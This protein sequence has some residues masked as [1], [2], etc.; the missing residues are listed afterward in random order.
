M[1]FAASSFHV[2]LERISL[3]H[4]LDWRAVLDEMFRVSEEY[5]LVEEPVDD[6]RTE[7]KRNTAAARSLFLEL[8]HAVGYRHNR[9]LEVVELVHEVRQR[10]SVITTHIE[11]RDTPVA[12]QDYFSG[13]DSFA[14]ESGRE[15][16]WHERLEALKRQL[17]PG[18]LS[19]DDT[20]LI[21]ARK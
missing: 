5:V 17:G 2:V 15:G 3:H 18:L 16:Y 7:E 12:F 6:L 9:H 11:R 8:Q 20:I 14:G 13:F 4:V 10:G 21:L 1:A 19:E